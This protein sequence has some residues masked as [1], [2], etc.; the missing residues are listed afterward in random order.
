LQE[1]ISCLTDILARDTAGRTKY[2][3]EALH[4][5]GVLKERIGDIEGAR[6]ALTESLNGFQLLGS[7]IDVARVNNNIAILHEK[8][9]D[10][11]SA[12]RAC[13]K[14]LALAQQ[15]G[16]PASIAACLNTQ[17]RLQRY[18]GDTTSALIFL[19]KALSMYEAA[20]DTDT[21]AAVLHNIGC[22]ASDNGDLV[23]AR[24]A[25]VQSLVLFKEISHPSW[26]AF[27]LHNLGDTKCR[28]GDYTTGFA[29]LVEALMIRFR[30]G[31]HAGIA[32]SLD[33]CSAAFFTLSV[34]TTAVTIASAAHLERTKYRVPAT[35][36][37]KRKFD[38]M[39]VS[40]RSS[41]GQDNFT[42]AWKLGA[43][44]TG[45]QVVDYVVES[46]STIGQVVG[47]G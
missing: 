9:G 17:A 26:T 5:L 19:R 47:M 39:I 34:N 10:Y 35:P 18:N 46:S 30:L 32:S 11:E 31:D 3:A 40:L 4:G 45:R 8:S 12:S 13:A 37:G 44:M 42:I 22:I 28:Q 16:D 25:F 33:S 41:L 6:L 1:G 14:G 43:F 7:T 20:G 27:A 15:I 36:S 38:A 2:D 21:A 29:D 24:I 23:E